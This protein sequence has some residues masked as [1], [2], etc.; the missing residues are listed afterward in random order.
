LPFS[1]WQRPI[2]FDAVLISAQYA[3]IW[4]DENADWLHN[5]LNARVAENAIRCGACSNTVRHKIC[6]I[7]L[8]PR[9]WHCA[10]CSG[11]DNFSMAG[12]KRQEVGE[13]DI[14]GL[15]YFDK[16][17]P[18]LVRLHSAGC[19]RDKAGNR[20]LHFDQY[21]LLI[22]LYLFNPIVTS[23]RGVQQAIALA[24]VQKKLGCPR[25]G[26]DV[27]FVSPYAVIPLYGGKV[28]LGKEGAR[29][30]MDAG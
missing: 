5:S 3:L 13:K 23:L 25:A 16:I 18:L 7:H 6:A 30:I 28:E 12:K 27:R 14:G 26:L 4:A 10:I 19:R 11:A 17:A 8:T 15:K 21:C 1:E 29:R 22:L 20:E 2:S 9:R 24:K